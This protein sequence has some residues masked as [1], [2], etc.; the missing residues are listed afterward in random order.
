MASYKH[1]TLVDKTAKMFHLMNAEHSDHWALKRGQYAD[2]NMKITEMCY[3]F[4][5]G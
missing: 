4:Q 2:R 1:E 3:T 5:N